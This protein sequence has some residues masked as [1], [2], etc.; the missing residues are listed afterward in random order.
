MQ[1]KTQFN[2]IVLAKHWIVADESQCCANEFQR[3]AKDDIL[4]TTDETSHHIMSDNTNSRA[5]IS[6]KTDSQSLTF[7]E[8]SQESQR[9]SMASQM[10]SSWNLIALTLSSLHS[11]RGSERGFKVI[12]NFWF[13][14]AHLFEDV[15]K[16]C[17]FFELSQQS[18]LPYFTLWRHRLTAD[19][20]CD[21][22][23]P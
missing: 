14:I 22:H 12:S 3:F 6:F 9:F 17:K 21:S 8:S 11:H 19:S 23:T 20:S 5:V 2:N 15:E 10:L 18:L 13:K 1:S 4:F 7:A 16:V